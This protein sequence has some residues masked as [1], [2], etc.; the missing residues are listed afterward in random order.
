MLTVLNNGQSFGWQKHLLIK[1]LKEF[2]L[3]TGPKIVLLNE[4]D[5][6]YNFNRDEADLI[7]YWSS[8]ALAFERAEGRPIIP[9]SS[10]DRVFSSS[11]GPNNK[12][13][14]MFWVSYTV[15]LYTTRYRLLIP[16]NE[17]FSN[18]M[19]ST[20]GQGRLNRCFTFCK[21]AENDLLNRNVSFSSEWY[22]DAAMPDAA[23]ELLGQELMHDFIKKYNNL[24]PHADNRPLELDWRKMKNRN[25]WQSQ[26]TK[27]IISAIIIPT[28]AYHDS[29]LLYISE[30]ILHNPEFFM[31]E[32]TVKGL[33]SGRPCI[34]VSCQH[35][36][37]QLN[38]LGF[39]TWNAV[40]DESYDDEENVALRIEKSVLSAKDFMR[41]N[42]LNSPKKLS[43]IQDITNHNKNILFN[44]DWEMYQRT[45][46][47]LILKDLG[48]A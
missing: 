21:F 17:I 28:H 26:H 3:C 37:K 7:I 23:N 6:W 36:L 19:L 2:Q 24:I 16:K 42:V 13:N 38:Q 30:T 25:E 43:M 35:F 48:L 14:L 11:S 31:T 45:A 18:N 40:L 12:N 22:F 15:K 41:S 33:L 44:T 27:N 46:I 32:K 9:L 29:S 10:K 4:K 39:R 20:L 47:S 8:E 1:T 34:I 5:K